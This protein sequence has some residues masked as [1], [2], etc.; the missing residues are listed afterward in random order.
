MAFFSKAALQTLTHPAGFT[1]QVLRRFGQNQGLLLAGAVAY[2]ALL[3]VLPLLIL[4]IIV[5]SHLVDQTELFLTVGRYLEWLV[6]SQSKAVL[7]D[8]TSFL[9]NRVAIGAVLVATMLFFSAIAFGVLEKAL[10][11]IFAHRGIALR[12]HALVS[13]L[14][15]YCV[16]AVLGIILLG[17]TLASTALQAMAEE[18]VRILARDWSLRGVAGGLFHLLG[19]TV[20][21]LLLTAL[22]LVMPVGR[23]RLRHALMAGVAVTLLWEAIR[24][25]LVWYFTSLSMASVVYGSLTTA[26]IALF[27]MEIVA[28]LLLLGAQAIAEYEKLEQIEQPEQ[29]EP[30]KPGAT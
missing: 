1:L 27:S 24:H 3:S 18:N 15:P 26:V 25:L 6:P 19:L 20:E 10:A 11:V 13:A 22:Y 9:D 30:S 8:V 2:Y 12:R 28:T 14:L 17:V 23:T 16:V 21:A 29:L 5:L 7:A 4:S